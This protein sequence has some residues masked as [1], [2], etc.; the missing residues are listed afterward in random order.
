VTP[1][2][3]AAQRAGIAFLLHEYVHDP[4]AESYS[5][6]AA[7][8]LGADPARVYKTL[9]ASVDGNLVVA[10][11]SAEQSLDLKALATAVGGKRARMA[12][13]ADAERA[14]GYVAGG[15][16]PLGQRRALPCVMDESALQGEHMFISAGRRGL[17]MQLS[18]SDLRR[19]A[20]ARVAAIGR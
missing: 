9:V 8:A 15:I 10:L 6:E 16:S 3:A 13:V 2:I 1:A 7:E 4:T 11:V 19:V 18:P 12:P 17:E 20:R 5:G 14:T